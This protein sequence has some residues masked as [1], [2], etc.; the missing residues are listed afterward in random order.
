MIYKIKLFSQ[1]QEVI[2][3]NNKNQEQITVNIK[4][5]LIYRPHFLSLRDNSKWE[6]PYYH[7]SLENYY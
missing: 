6:L 4:P 2:I 5:S 7:N 1:Q 3:H